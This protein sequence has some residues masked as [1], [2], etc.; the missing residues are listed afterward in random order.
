[1]TTLTTTMTMMVLMR[2]RRDARRRRSAG[3]RR[4]NM[5]ARTTR[6]TTITARTSIL[7][8]QVAIVAVETSMG[9]RLIR[10]TMKI[11]EKSTAV[12][13]M[14]VINTVNNHL[15]AANNPM[16]NKS[17]MVDNSHTVVTR[18]N[19]P[20]EASREKNM[21]MADDVSDLDPAIGTNIGMSTAPVGIERL[22][23][24]VY[25]RKKE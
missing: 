9:H 11:E 22:L 19:I 16:V 21:V 3:R 20:T 23:F 7:S 25:A 14:E 4:R 24:P 10:D 12:S 5:A 15:M 17:H 13:N 6:M 1:M 18:N 2:R 8:T